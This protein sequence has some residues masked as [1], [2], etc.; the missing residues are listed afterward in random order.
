MLLRMSFPG[1]PRFA[2]AIAWLAMLSPP[3]TSA[4]EP[5]Q[6]NVPYSCTDGITR[7]ITRCAS[8]PRGE[9]CFWREEK[10]GQLIV[11]RYNV[12]GQM[13]GWL[14]TCKAPAVNAP[15]QAATPPAATPRP[16]GPLNPAYLAGFPDVERVKRDIHDADPVQ[17]VAH[18]IAILDFLQTYVRRMQMAPER[19]YGSVTP[20]EQRLMATYA[21]A[22]EELKQAYVKSGG[23][24][25]ARTL[26]NAVGRYSFSNTL[27]GE[28]LALLSPAT[29]AEY[30]RINGAANAHQ[31]AHVDEIKRQNEQAQAQAAA[32]GN[33][34]SPFVRNDPG[35][36]AV[37]RCLELGGGDMECMGKG[38]MT[39]LFDMSG[40]NVN[41]LL[42]SSVR[43][44]VRLGGTFRTDAGLTLHFDT[45][46]A[47]IGGCGKLVPE[48]RGYKITKRGDQLEVTVTNASKPLVVVLSRDGRITGPAAFDV[49]GKIIVGYRKYWVESRRVSDNS[50]I[51]GSGHEE[52]EPIYGPKTERCGFAALRASAPVQS[53][54]SLI[55]S[56]VGIASGQAD[57]AAARAG[58]LEAPAGARL[59]G[60]YAGSG[61]KLEFHPTAVVIDCGDAHV[62]RPYAV[63]IMADRVAVT[64]RNGD[65]PVSLALKPD[66]TLSGAGTIDVAGRAVTGVNEKGA[67]FAPKNARCPVAALT[68][69]Q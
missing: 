55:G 50:V 20:D 52:S 22:G 57:P 63:D 49:D 41:A 44:G 59:T 54:P 11:E 38:F 34:N 13:D 48:G 47:G 18:Q 42:A 32:A 19:P 35:T 64:L 66:G 62:L 15:A 16:A 45:E 36:L 3:L 53:E 67:T 21:A 51:P 5:L 17:T 33:G 61:L 68:P 40:V 6:F 10:N 9:V 27:G 14:K 2:T 4:Q 69:Q 30:R 25:A 1:I 39:G 29:L 65:V 23:P 8:N 31:Q 24:D 56:I 28:A 12:R 37:R 7:I 26:Q 58:T 46:N 60:N 43:A